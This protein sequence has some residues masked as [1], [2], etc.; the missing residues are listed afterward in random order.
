MTQ[1]PDRWQHLKPF[2][3]KLFKER[4][5]R[6]DEIMTMTED[7]FTIATTY[8]FPMATVQRAKNHAFGKGVSRYHLFPDDDMAAAWL[9]LAKEQGNSLDKIFLEHEIYESGLVENQSMSQKE[10]HDLTQLK[11]PWS[12]LLR[13]SQQ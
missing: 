7:I 9:R 12:I 8:N 1:N 10:A 3:R 13:E 11:F 4:I 6:Y 2:I 5:Q